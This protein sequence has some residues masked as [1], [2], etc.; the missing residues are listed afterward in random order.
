M[1]SIDDVWYKTV[2]RLR[3]E[4]GLAWKTVA[5]VMGGGNSENSVKSA[6]Y[7]YL[8]KLQRDDAS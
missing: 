3:F 1:K 2:F 4:R 7:R 8:K 6:C 5:A